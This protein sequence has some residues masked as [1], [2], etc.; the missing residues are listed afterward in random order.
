MRHSR[1][2]FH[3]SPYIFYWQA[4]WKERWYHGYNFG[5]FVCYRRVLAWFLNDFIHS[6]HACQLKQREILIVD[7]QAGCLGRFSRKRTGSKVEQKLWF[8]LKP[9]APPIL[10]SSSSPHPPPSSTWSYSS[11]PPLPSPSIKT[12]MKS[13]AYQYFKASPRCHVPFYSTRPLKVS[14]AKSQKNTTQIA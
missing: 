5:H 3:L 14:L 10:S 12:S 13:C 6:T 4:C 1:H 9:P 11:N 7:S 8:N 2:N